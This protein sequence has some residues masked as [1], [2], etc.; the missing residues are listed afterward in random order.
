MLTDSAERFVI[1]NMGWVD[2]GQL[3]CLDLAR[4]KAWQHPLGPAGYL[5]LMPGQG[6]L[7]VAIRHE[8]ARIIE[9]TIHS[10]GSPPEVLARVRLEMGHASFEGQVELWS[11]VPA[12]FVAH[13]TRFQDLV[14]PLLCLIDHHRSKVEF[15]ELPWYTTGYDLGYQDLLVPVRV[16]GSDLLLMPIQRDS[17]PVIYDLNNRKPMGTIRLAGRNG[18]PT[19]QFRRKAPELWANDY[20]TLLRLDVASWRVQNSIRLQDEVLTDLNGRQTRTG[21]FIGEYAFDRD[22][23]RCAVARPYSEDIVLIDTETFRQV[24]RVE[25][26]SQPLHVALLSDG[27]LIARDWKTGSLIRTKL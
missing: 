4:D 17:N 20:D 16:P 7:F 12:T 14:Q 2:G 26:G 8:S 15:Q 6:D 1:D 11:S 9:A 21:A 19:L 25:A 13:H 3:W 10:A 5:V 18:N 24:R 27:R 23:S 22:E